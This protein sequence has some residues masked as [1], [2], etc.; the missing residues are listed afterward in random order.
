[1]ATLVTG[2]AGFIGS[3]LCDFLVGSGARVVCIDNLITGRRANI[4]H[5]LG[6]P[7]FT[8]FEH[9]VSD[10]LPE[11]PHLDEIYHLASP[12]SPPAYQLLQLAT[13]RVNSE[14]TRNLL[15]VAARHRA[16]FL[17]ASTSEVYGDPLV[18]PQ[19]ESYRGN[20]STT[21]PRSM[22]D[23][24][25][26]FGEALTQAYRT[27][28]GVDT[29]IVRIFNTY[30]PRLDP[31]DGRVVSNF[32]VQALGG[33]PLTIY[34]DGSQTRS[35][36]YVDDL[37]AGITRVMA[38]SCDS[39]INLGNPEEYRV[40]DLARLVH[41]VL[42]TDTGIAFHPLPGDDPRQRRPDISLAWSELGWKPSVSVTDGLRRTVEHFRH[43]LAQGIVDPRLDLP[44]PAG[45]S[46]TLR[47]TG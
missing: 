41:S 34:G 43:E 26:R 24:A 13:M 46:A 39:P 16:R 47:A 4:A 29:R 40:I 17:Y 25:K 2:G 12:A 10:D 33:H 32:L 31:G 8:F 15:D 42:G 21:G 7:R 22:Y 6:H 44:F 19:P 27:E 20:V 1:M 38:S 30:G 23:E 36:Q 14:G 3:H 11:L 5:L 18:H 37:I 45:S 35:F 28:R 9:D